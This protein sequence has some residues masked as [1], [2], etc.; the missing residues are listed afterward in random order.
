MHKIECKPDNCKERSEK[1]DLFSQKSNGRKCTPIGRK[2]TTTGR[3]ADRETG[4]EQSKTVRLPVVPEDLIDV[5]FVA[6]T[7]PSNHGEI[8]MSSLSKNLY[9]GIS[10]H[11]DQTNTRAEILHLEPIFAIKRQVTQSVLV[12]RTSCSSQTYTSRSSDP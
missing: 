9:T 2:C 7:A 1:C 11:T 3:P 6:F 12:S 8:Y 10:S 5:L 4:R